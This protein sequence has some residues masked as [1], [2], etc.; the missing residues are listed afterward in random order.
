M[1][2]IVKTII[3]S[4]IIMGFLLSTTFVQ[5]KDVLLKFGMSGEEIKTVQTKLKELGYFNEKT[6]GYYGEVTKGAVEKFQKD[7]KFSVDGVVGPGTWGSLVGNDY[8]LPVEQLSGQNIIQNTTLKELLKQDMNGEHI[9]NAQIRLK[10]LGYFNEETT[11][12][13]GTVTKSAVEKF[14]KANGL[15]IDGT[16]GINTWNKLFNNSSQKSVAKAKV[17]EPKAE[18]VQSS[19]GSVPKGLSLLSWTNVQGIFP[20]GTVATVIDINTGI[21]FKIK[22][23]YGTNHADCETL[24]SEDTAIMKKVFGGSWNWERRAIILVINGRELAASIAGVPHAGVDSLPA[25]A[26]VSNRSDGYGRGENLDAVK[27]NNMSGVFD[28]HFLNSRTHSTNKIDALHQAAVKKAANY[29][30]NH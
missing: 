17:P 18:I 16:I 23:T 14:Q 8:K 1:K 25:N 5:A 27:G 15:G 22:R 10:E 19:R 9:K 28:V 12:Y 6:T 7:R 29:I 11:G 30:E 21:K 3:F 24:T 2:K 20:R 4:S 26:T 13:F